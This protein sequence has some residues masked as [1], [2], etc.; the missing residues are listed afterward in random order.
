LIDINDAS[1]WSAQ[2]VIRELL[3]DIAF[4]TDD[5]CDDIIIGRSI[6]E[7]ETRYALSNI[8]DSER[9]LWISRVFENGV[10][11]V[12]DFNDTF[13]NSSDKLKLD[14][15]KKMMYDELHPLSN[16]INTNISKS[17]ISSDNIFR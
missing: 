11:D 6:T 12:K 2:P 16:I 10:P 4:D 15:L 9:C 17:P 3:K 7:Y 5:R 13:D 1:F 8:I 14:N